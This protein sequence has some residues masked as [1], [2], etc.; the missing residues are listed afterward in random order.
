[1]P[2]SKRLDNYL[3][4]THKRKD[5]DLLI[6]MELMKRLLKAKGLHHAAR[7]SDRQAIFGRGAWPAPP[8]LT[9]RVCAG[10]KRWPAK[11]SVVPGLA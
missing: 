1:M 11:R 6:P 2:T 3:K 5:Y 9:G 10:S 4:L 8:G 7:A